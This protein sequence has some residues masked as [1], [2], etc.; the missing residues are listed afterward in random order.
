MKPLRVDWTKHSNF[1]RLAY[2]ILCCESGLWSTVKGSYEEKATCLI[3]T[4]MGSGRSCRH[5]SGHQSHWKHT[6]NTSMCSPINKE[7]AREKNKKG[8]REK[9]KEIMKWKSGGERSPCLSGQETGF[10][11][12]W[13][14][15]TLRLRE[16]MY[17]YLPAYA[18]EQVLS[19]GQ[20][21][22][23][24]MAVCRCAWVGFPALRC[25]RAVGWRCL[26]S[27]APTG[28]RVPLLPRSKEE[29]LRRGKKEW[30]VGG[31]GKV[32]WMEKR[33]EW[34]MWNFRWASI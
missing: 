4:Q 13:P 23:V 26:L 22:L 2:S 3:I 31:W 32:G 19:D 29:W 1:Q 11:N 17:V 14:R 6:E 28:S 12:L 8:E 24:V 34:K 16:R 10:F 20:M 9:E 30:G 18:S 21:V 5:T 33:K 25:M 7:K 15:S 27:T